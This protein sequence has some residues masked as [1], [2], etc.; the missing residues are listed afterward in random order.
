MS[1]GSL[2]ILKG[3]RRNNF[4]YL[5]DNAVA[6]NLAASEQLIA[7]LPGYGNWGSDMLV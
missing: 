7:I 6:E 2:V 5:K 3:V 4:Y 1:S